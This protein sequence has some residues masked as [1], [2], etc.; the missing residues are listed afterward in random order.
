MEERLRSR[1]GWGLVA[2]IHPTDYELRLGILQSKSEQLES[3]AIP[4]RVLEFLAHKITSSVRELEGALNRVVAHAT[5]IGRPVTL[6]RVASLA[7]GLLP[8]RPGDLTF[9]H[10]RR[11]ADE[12]VTVDDAA[13]ARAVLWLFRRAKLVVE[14]SGAATVAAILSRRVPAAQA[15]DGPTV[16]VLSGGNIGL[17]TLCGLGAD[18]GDPDAEAPPE[19][20][21]A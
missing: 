3:V 7:D 13:I 5:L 10:V 11:F 14:T 9:E 20:G 2:D 21:L 4:E 12:I 17:D 1:L 19:P 18:F 8:V 15:G 6:E 16:V